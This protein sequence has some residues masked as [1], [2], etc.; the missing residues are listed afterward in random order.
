MEELIAVRQAAEMKLR[1]AAAANSMPAGS[2]S[3]INSTMG[4]FGN[5]SSNHNSN[6]N[7]SGGAGSML[8]RTI[9]GSI[10]SFKNTTT[11]TLSSIRLTGGGGSNPAASPPPAASTA[12]LMRRTT[13]LL[14]GSSTTTTDPLNEVYSLAC[15]GAVAPHKSLAQNYGKPGSASYTV[16]PHPYFAAGCYLVSSKSSVIAIL[17]VIIHHKAISFKLN[18]IMYYFLLFFTVCCFASFTVRTKIIT[19]SMHLQQ[20]MLLMMLVVRCLL[21]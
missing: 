16:L 13:T 11:N 20:E 1:Y 6:N 15:C 9:T 8:T 10:N 21:S 2:H 19:A 4:G 12:T 5:N 18:Y 7:N 14:S 3:S 17:Q